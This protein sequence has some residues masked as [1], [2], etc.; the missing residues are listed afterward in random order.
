M[1]HLQSN[2]RLLRKLKTVSFRVL[3][4]ETGIGFDS[5][6]KYEGGETSKEQK[7]YPSLDG[8]ITLAKFYN[9]TCHQLCFNDLSIVN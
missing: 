4:R 2:L 9:V 8:I 7:I 5:L 1:I 6:K 3:T